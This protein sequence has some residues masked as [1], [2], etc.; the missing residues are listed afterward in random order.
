MVWNK[1]EDGTRAFSSQMKKFLPSDAQSWW[2]L[3]YD[4]LNLNLLPEQDS[5]GIILIESEKQAK[6]RPYHKQKLCYILS[7]MRHFAMETV[8][9]GIPVVYVTTSEQYD[10]PLYALTQEF[11]S[12]NMY[13]AAERELRLT[14]HQLI[15][16]GAIIEHPHPGW[17]TPQHWFTET[18]GN[19]PPFRMDRFYRRVRKEKGWLMEGDSPVGGK[20]SHDADNRKLWKG[21]HQLPYPPSY[22]VDEVDEE[23]I[24][25]VNQRFEEH[26]GDARLNHLPTNYDDHR[27]ALD[28]LSDILT[29]FGPYEDAMA[30]ESRGLFHSRLASSMNLHR[31]LPQEVIDIV[32]DANVPLNSQEGYLRQMIWREYV[33]HVHEV[34]DGFHHLDVNT[35]MSSNRTAGWPMELEKDET[36]NPNHLNQTRSLPMAYWGRKSGMDCLDWAVESVM[37][38]AWTHHIP[39]LMVL[40]NLAQLMD[41]EPRQLTDWFHAAFVDAFDWVVEPNVLGMG[42]FALGDAMMTKP[43]VSGSPYIK[44]MGDFCSSCEFHPAKTCPIS[45]MYWAYFERHKGAFAGNHRLAMTLRTLEKRSEEKKQIDRATF[46]HVT[47]TLGQGQSLAS[48]T[49]L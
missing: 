46:D 14:L 3:P 11:G 30:K 12:I 1:V 47:R 24:A 40:S 42:T 5:I 17:L 10:E 4:Q 2:Y 31:V 7:N 16:E 29:L 38:E 37:D 27:K 36:D 48:Q 33:H 45:P 41:I 20:F 26:P 21:E 22:T 19:E 9:K 44:K 43:Y 15:E 6:R 35:T 23:V 13:R 49:K 25:F 8:S 32:V 39:R 34:T 18:L 28:F